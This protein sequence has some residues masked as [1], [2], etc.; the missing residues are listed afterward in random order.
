MRSSA[1]A[2]GVGAALVASSALI[3]ALAQPPEPLATCWI[4]GS[5]APQTRR[6]QKQT[7]VAQFHL[8]VP[9]NAGTPGAAV[10]FGIDDAG[11]VV[12]MGQ[13]AYQ[14]ALRPAHVKREFA[15]PKPPLTPEQVPRFVMICAWPL[16]DDGKPTAA[17]VA[18]YGE[19]D[20]TRTSIRRDGKVSETITLHWAAVP[21]ARVRDKFGKTDW[22]GEVARTKRSSAGAWMIDRPSTR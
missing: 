5:Y 17:P 13:T 19:R 20:D 8:V 14:P 3:A 10:A 4:I 2:W 18:G 16:G 1:A 12:W 11:R 22:C 6:P 9:G 15:T 7:Y 21:A